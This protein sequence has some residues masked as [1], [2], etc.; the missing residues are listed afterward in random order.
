MAHNQLPSPTMDSASPRTMAATIPA[1]PPLAG[2]PDPTTPPATTA[3]HPACPPAAS[4]G[5][6]TTPPDDD[7]R[8]PPTTAPLRDHDGCFKTV[9]RKPSASLV[10]ASIPPP[11]NT[12]TSTTST[13]SPLVHAILPS[14]AAPVSL[15][16]TPPKNTGQSGT[17]RVGIA[18]DRN[19][20]CRRTMEDSHSFFYNFD[21]TAG[22]GFFT[23]FDGHAG[24]QAA[25][26][27]GLHFHEL[28][29][30]QL[31]QRKAQRQTVASGP[32]FTLKLPM[33]ASAM[34]MLRQADHSTNQ[35]QLSPPPASALP[36][37]P[38]SLPDVS[39]SRSSPT[40]TTTTI[41]TAAAA[42]PWDPQHRGGAPVVRADTVIPELLHY[43][44]L[45]ADQRISTD[46]DSHSGCTA[47]V[48]YLELQPPPSPPA[49]EALVPPSTPLPGQTQFNPQQLLLPPTRSGLGS[50]SS[51]SPSKDSTHT[52]PN[53][54]RRWTLY[55]ANVGDA[56]GVLA[57]N[58]RAVRLTYDHKG[59]DPHEV[60][61]ISEAGGFVINNR[62]NGVLAVTRA[63]G[64]TS[65]KDVVVG[66]PYTTETEL[67]PGDS[68]LIM[69]CDGLWDVCSDQ[70]AVN[71]IKDT[72]DAQK[73]SEILTKY[74]L[75][76]FSR[77]NITVMVIKL[78][79]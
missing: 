72:S 54:H 26:W 31:A 1:S 41:T 13:S 76:N 47:V 21:N 66:H 77:D 75:D 60:R 71:L 44:F 19:R 23:I 78:Y 70:K 34:K 24:K 56:R 22:Q 6:A 11:I 67:T 40:N 58:G 61:R 17:F 53:S 39:P 59:D 51:T 74:A 29:L 65:M 57:R 46:L 33:A 8:P 7:S 49:S 52:A 55:T 4:Q 10:R 28:F 14:P 35:P 3:S 27:C 32:G 12:T 18:S 79:H 63:L 64:D 62:V 48:A 9:L 42:L 45:E 38:P 16:D 25:E 15:S 69:A 2:S 36:V 37:S 43:T 5:T 30:A 68:F 20:R 73:A 50:A